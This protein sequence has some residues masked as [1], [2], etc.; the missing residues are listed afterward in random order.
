MRLRAFSPMEQKAVK[1]AATTFRANPAF[2][3]E[4]AIMELGIGEALVST[5]DEKGQPTIVQRTLVRPPNSRVGPITDAERNKVIAASPV[6]YPEKATDSSAEQARLQQWADGA[7]EAKAASAD[8]KAATKT[9]SGGSSRSDSF[10]TT[11]GKTLIKTGVPL[12]TRVLTDALKG[13]GR[14][15]G[16]GGFTGFGALDTGDGASSSPA[17]KSKTENA[18]GEKY[19]PFKSINVSERGILGGRKR[20]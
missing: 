1:A 11:L 4:K 17:G 15:G 6:E 8:D 20:Q 5:L 16:S 3:T 9:S 12:A 14:R 19:V 10:W 18:T 2:D 7:A 13:R